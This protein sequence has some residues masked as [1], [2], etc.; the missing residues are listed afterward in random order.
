MISAA[1]TGFFTGFSLILAIGAQNAFVLRQGILRSHVFAICLF[2]SIFDAV[3]IAIG[4]LGFGVIVDRWAWLPVVMA[5][6]G[7]AF[8]IVYGVMRFKA[9]LKG[10]YELLLK[11]ETASLAASMTVLVALTVLNPHVYL[12]TLGLIGAVSTQF[13]GTEKLAFGIAAMTASF[14]FFFS[15]GYGARLLAPIMQSAANWRILDFLIAC[16]M[17]AIAAALLISVL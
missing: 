14:T 13:L 11:G 1:F 17:W 10:D 16:V 8:L 9:A 15:L 6:L 12:D 4:V 7:T 2:C 5:L 3:L